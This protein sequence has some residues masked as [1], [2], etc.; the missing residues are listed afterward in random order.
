MTFDLPFFRKES[1]D[2]TLSA[3]LQERSATKSSKLR[4]ERELGRQLEAENAQWQDL[5]RRLALYDAQILNQ[6]RDQAEAALLAYQS[7]AGD[8]ANVMRAYIGYLNTR[9]DHIRLSID[10][11]QSYAVLANLAG[12]S[13]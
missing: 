10:R 13:S 1:V 3:A 4:L 5:T 6:S 8:F 2:S 11:A 12:L 9:I 7:D